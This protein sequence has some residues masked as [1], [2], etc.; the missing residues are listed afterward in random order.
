MSYDFY[1]SERGGQFG[2]FTWRNT[3]PIGKL[4]N[5]IETSHRHFW[6][7]TWL[8]TAAQE[9]AWQELIQISED[10]GFYD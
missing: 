3:V 1:I 9:Q 7:R 2:W 10:L 6:G 4:P 8:H 5:W